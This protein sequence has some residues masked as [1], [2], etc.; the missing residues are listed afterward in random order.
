M[1][2]V[3]VLVILFLFI[4]CENPTETTNFIRASKDV[5]IGFDYEADYDNDGIS[6][7]QEITNN[8]NPYIANVPL[9]DLEQ[10]TNFLN[11]EGEKLER[12]EQLDSLRSNIIKLY[13][14]CYKNTNCQ[15]L[16]LWRSFYQFDLRNITTNVSDELILNFKFAK[17][18]ELNEIRQNVSIKLNDEYF[19]EKEYSLIDNKLIINFNAGRAERN[20]YFVDLS[21]FWTKTTSSKELFTEL[22]SK[23]SQILIST[24]KKNMTFYVAPNIS[25]LEI[26]KQIEKNIKVSEDNQSIISFMNLNSQYKTNGYQWRI[27]RTSG[28]SINEPT[29]IQEKI[30]IVYVKDEQLSQVNIAASNL[31]LKLDQKVNLNTLGSKTIKMKIIANSIVEKVEASNVSIGARYICRYGSSGTYDRT[32]SIN[33]SYT[34]VIEANQIWQPDDSRL[35]KLIISQGHNLVDLKS[36]R[37]SGLL[38]DTIENATTTIEITL[39]D[40]FILTEPIQMTNLSKIL[41][42]TKFVGVNSESHGVSDCNQ[43]QL[44]ETTD[45]T[46]M[47]NSLNSG[48]RNLYE[49][50]DFIIKLFQ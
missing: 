38:K 24:D 16:P 2:N 28:K 20:N 30:I 11:S 41:I 8:Q 29:L 6:N 34:K 4:S 26:L 37:K 19:H 22:E 15:T 12:L 40:S 5:A 35:E 9:I 21:N 49:K 3:I 31:E 32:G 36:L 7:Y 47:R 39:P 43:Q 14:N 18:V 50:T 17:N 13:G 23:D 42:D 33:F 48:N 25:L 27:V 45:T 44:N 10:D 1:K 46:G